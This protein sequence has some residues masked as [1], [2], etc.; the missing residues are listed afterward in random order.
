MDLAAHFLDNAGKEFRQLKSQADR[1][2]AQIDDERFFVAPDPES[3]SLA[4]IC[5]H[6]AG[7]QWSRWRDFLTADGEKSDRHRDTEFEL[8]A[9]A[10][11][12]ELMAAWERGWNLVFEEMGKL[13]PEDASKTITIRGE[14]HTVVAAIQRQLTHNASHIGQIVYLAKHLAGGG[15]HTISV[16]R[17]RSEE[18][19]R[20]M[21]GKFESGKA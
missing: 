17:G 9:N 6:I 12:A 11:R 21:R 2:L 10:T 20:E 7:N 16:P 18:F 15:W 1:A 14:P 8:P 5:R 13:Q 19:N 4:V 3:N